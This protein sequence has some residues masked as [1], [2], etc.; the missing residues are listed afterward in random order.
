M[1]NISFANSI[2]KDITLQLSWFDQFQFAGY[3]IAK[4]KGFYKESGLNVNIKPFEFGID[5]PNAV[6][7]EKYDFAI[8]RE[9]L[10]LDKSN[11][12]KIVA[13]YSLFQASP[14]ILISTKESG[15]N[16]ITDFKNKKIMTTIHDLSEVSLKSMILSKSINTKNLT[17]IK[18]THNIDDLI[19]KKVDI[20]SAYS[21]KAPYYLQQ[22]GIEYNTFVPRDYGFDMYSDFL[23][24]NE[25]NINNNLEQV[26][27]F[28]EASL[29]GWEYA[30]SNIEETVDLILSKYNTQKLTKDE[31]LFEAKI[32]KELSYYKTQTLGNIDINKLQRIYDLYSVMGLVK[33]K[34]EI[35]DFVLLDKNFNIFLKN[36][37]SNLSKYIELPYIYF[38]IILFMILVFLIINEHLKLLKKEKQLLIKNNELIK[39]KKKLDEVFEASGEGIWD[40]N[41]KT[42]HVEHNHT[43]YDILGLDHIKD[44]AKDFTTLIH[45]EDREDVLKEINNIIN[46]NSTNY[47]SEHRLLKKNGEIIWILNK[48]RIVEWDKEGK[49]LRMAGSFSNITQRKESEQILLEQHK[50]LLKSEKLA[51]L[52]EMIG[53]IA[54]QWRQPLST[55]STA[56]TGMQIQKEFDLLDDDTFNKSCDAINNNAQY[57]SKTIDDFRN[58]IKGDSKS[59]HFNL[60]NNT[61]S[62][63]KLVDS[64]IHDSHINII[65]HL[66]ED[67]N[68]HGF[69][70]ELIQC[71]INIFN[72]AKDALVSNNKEDNRYIFISQEIIN[73]NVIIKFKDN[74]MGIPNNIIDKIFHPYFTTKHQSQGTGL[75][76]HM[77]YNFI[78]DVMDGT[79]EANNVEFEHNG[80]KC[81]GAEFTI[82]LPI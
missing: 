57:L 51:T 38:F 72:N 32:L 82:T 7:S 73:N 78:V 27:K 10:I 19:Q 44:T 15:I 1:F 37:W 29:K 17:F 67:K 79:I 31:L 40:W 9:T 74:A 55:I 56:A 80:Q 23:Y 45:P 65:L 71:F 11:N 48:G 5:I 8:G 43:W 64:T 36:I 46:N 20:I 22:K 77:T 62:F 58:F 33:N 18:H 4:E 28:K 35:K 3:Y 70:N 12:K 50:K 66:I 68:I 47:Q 53:N 63:L 39:S 24:T 54:H 42:N 41:I 69:P 26:L 76:L 52:G 49:A 2:N 25:S 34:V 30:Y 16:T 14:L 61:D 21:S 75:G 59:I 13:L 6:S 81:I 60:K